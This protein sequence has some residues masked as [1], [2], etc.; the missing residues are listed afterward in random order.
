V[1]P[2]GDLP[3]RRQLDGN[4]DVDLLVDDHGYDELYRLASLTCLGAVSQVL[5]V[6]TLQRRGCAYHNARAACWKRFGILARKLV[7]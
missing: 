7:L 6:M 4:L 2:W 3:G 1:Y 5:R